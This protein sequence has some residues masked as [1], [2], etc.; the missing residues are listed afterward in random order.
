VRELSSIQIRSLWHVDPL[1]GNDREISK[2]TAAVTRK[3][4]VNSN[5]GMVFSVRS[6]PR[7]YK[8]DK[9]GVEFTELVGDLEN[10]FCSVVVGCC[11]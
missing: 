1:L 6:L 11:C 3:R 8:Q 7:C 9:L 10:C 4:P 5:R 2:Y